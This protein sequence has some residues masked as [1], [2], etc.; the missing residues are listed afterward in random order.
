[1]IALAAP[2]ESGLNEVLRVCSV[3]ARKQERVRGTTENGRGI[4]HPCNSA[5]NVE[6]TTSTSAK[7]SEFALL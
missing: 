5:K 4:C 3:A 2:R 7:S 1:V 6:F